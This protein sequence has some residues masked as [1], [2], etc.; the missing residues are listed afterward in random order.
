MSLPDYCYRAWQELN[1][2][3]NSEE[4]ERIEREWETELKKKQNKYETQRPYFQP[5]EVA[6]V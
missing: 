4:K 1:T 5:R 2:P 6:E 3:L